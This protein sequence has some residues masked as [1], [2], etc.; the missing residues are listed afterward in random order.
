M[1]CPEHLELNG[2]KQS[3][4]E[5][6]VTDPDSVITDKTKDLTLV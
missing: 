6:I 3:L 2:Y 1:S 5:L 4:Q